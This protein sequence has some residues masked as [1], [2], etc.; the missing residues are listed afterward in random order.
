M[1]GIFRHD[2]VMNFIRK[3]VLAMLAAAAVAGSRASSP[4]VIDLWPGTPP[5]NKASV[6]PEHDTTKAD[7][8]NVAGKAVIRLTDVGRPTLTIF[9]PRGRNTGA[10]VI[11]CPG[12][13]YRILAM[14]LEGAEI[15][16]WLNSI[17]VTAG[18]LKYRVP[19]Q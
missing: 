10:A 6:G 8:R 4:M 3:S 16:R 9:R 7:D 5:G 1:F 19:K 17:G 2:P 12:G 14:D 11:V 13:A 18:L 15:C